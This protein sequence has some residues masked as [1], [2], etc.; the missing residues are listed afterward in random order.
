MSNKI[1]N[2]A[3]RQYVYEH[4]RD[5]LNNG[6]LPVG[7]KINKIELC[8]QFNVSQ[9]PVNDAL[10]KLVGEGYLDEIPR[11]GYFVRE[12]NLEELALLFEIRAGIEGIAI[13]LCCERATDAELQE[14]IHTFD[15]FDEPFDEEKLRM[16]LKSDKRFHRLLIKYSR[17]PKLQ[18]ILDSRGFISRTYERGLMKSQEQ[19]LNEHKVIIT[20]LANRDKDTATSAIVNHLLSSRDYIMSQI[21]KTK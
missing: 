10:N 16:F 3:L 11:K 17:N 8:N 6:D 9:T 18:E 13:R 20:A 19:S 7:E 15:E 5:L 2:K 1:E 21:L 14:L 12:V 4:I